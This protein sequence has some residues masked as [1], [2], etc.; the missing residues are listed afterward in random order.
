MFTAPKAP[1]G[2]LVRVTLDATPVIG[3]RCGFPSGTDCLLLLEGDGAGQLLTSKVG[4][5][6]VPGLDVSRALELVMIEPSISN[7]MPTDF[8]IGGVVWSDGSFFVETT[9]D[10]AESR[11]YA[12]IASAGDSRNVGLVYRKITPQ[13]RVAK[14]IGV[15]DSPR[16]LSIGTVSRTKP[17]VRLRAASPK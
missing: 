8:R 16:H 3:W 1:V 14:A 7:V 12:C 6:P 5:A 15:R 4:A 17:S 9:G 13:F 2:A 10:D 11:V